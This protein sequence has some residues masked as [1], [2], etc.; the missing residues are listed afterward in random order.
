MSSRMSG[1][2]SAAAAGAGTAELA[3]SLLLAGERLRHD[4]VPDWILDPQSWIPGTRMPANFQRAPDGT[5]K[6]PLAGVIDAPMWSAQKRQL[7]REFSSE[8]ELHEYVGDARKVAG[9]MRD[10][11]WWNLER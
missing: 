6:S 2:G 3:P 8:E 10:H 5:F 1:H 7:M 9:A 4:W 11:I